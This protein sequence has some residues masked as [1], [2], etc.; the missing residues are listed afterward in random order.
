MSS[1]RLY[2]EESALVEEH[3]DFQRRQWR[4]QRMAWWLIVLVPSLAL[5]GFCGGGGMSTQ[6]AA[7][8]QL[9]LRYERFGR[10][11]GTTTLEIALPHI[12][13]VQDSV[14][15]LIDTAYAYAMNPSEITPSPRRVR[16]NGAHA[17]YVFDRRT[18]SDAFFVQ[19]KLHPEHWG[20]M[21]GTIRTDASPALVLQTFVWP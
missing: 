21:R 13:R 10:R 18:E 2:D 6:R 16:I 7:N 14:S 8:D 3:L 20:R 15:V 5:A 12:G 11:L 19:M 1:Q 4:I 9:Q 17:E